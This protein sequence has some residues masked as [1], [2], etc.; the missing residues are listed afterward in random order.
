MKYFTAI[1]CA[2]ILI[3]TTLPGT[4]IAQDNT[5]NEFTQ[6]FQGHFQ[7]AS[8]VL[9]LAE[10]M[11]ADKYSWRPS[12][13]V[14]SVEEVYAHLAYYNYFM[15]EKMGVETPSSVEVNQIEDLTGKEA[16]VD[17]LRRSIDHVTN[18]VGSMPESRLKETAQL[19]GQTYTGKA[20][21][22]QL[23]THMSEHVGQS[24]AYGRMN[25]IVPPWSR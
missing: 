20:M 11:P 16:V 21:L 4:A 5:Q 1:F 15:M 7:Y 9:S 3:A 13:E 18:A 10:A 23:I 25:G 6:L 24:I 19:Y 17:I 14:L 12:E 2:F 8:R 22:M